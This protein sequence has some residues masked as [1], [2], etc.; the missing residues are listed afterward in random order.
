MVMPSKEIVIITESFRRIQE[1]VERGIES[2]EIQMNVLR[3]EFFAP[4]PE[5]LKEFI[6]PSAVQMITLMRIKEATKWN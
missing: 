1:D 2:G 4:T 5:D 3:P 6:M